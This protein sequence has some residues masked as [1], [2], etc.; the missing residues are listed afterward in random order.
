V[1]KLTIKDVAEAAGVSV[2]T[3]SRVINNRP[4]VS[5]ATRKRIQKIIDE[6]GFAPSAVASSLR[7]GRSHTLGV[8]AT[9][10]EYFGPSRTIVGIEQQAEQLGY[11]LL[12]NLLHH[13]E[14]NHGESV[15]DAML[16]RRVDG[17]IW[18]I[19]EIGS[20]H[21]WLHR[22]IPDISTPVIMLS[23]EPAPGWTTAM[24]D[25][26]AG[27]R[28][29]TEH[30]LSQ[31]N[32]QIGIIMGPL[33]W[34]EARQRA[35][36]WQDVLT[37]AGIEPH[38]TLSVVGDWTAESGEACLFRLLEQIPT[39]TA[40]FACNDQ[41]AL[42]ALR[43][44]RKLGRDIPGDLAI[45]GF[46]DIPE[47]PFF[48]PPLTTVRQNL[49]QVGQQAIIMLDKVLEAR[50]REEEIEPAVFLSAPELIVRESSVRE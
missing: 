46:D 9:G 7:H 8:V 36:G 1:D 3:V 19:P 27:G 45:V 41:M 38:P 29:A 44:A 48:F 39:L 18:A 15:F 24:V 42:G 6:L 23:T 25:N 49:A 30:L 12:L 14:Y 34:W 10:I 4:D 13:A 37:G 21:E 31:G 43:A 50:R 20:N 40:V 35:Q 2:V 33:T 22:R 17:I 11:S 5:S 32:N 28:M 47:A 16:T 26:Y